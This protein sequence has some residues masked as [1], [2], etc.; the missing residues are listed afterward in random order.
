MAVWSDLRRLMV[1]AA[2]NMEAR[3]IRLV[4]HPGLTVLMPAGSLRALHVGWWG[5]ASLLLSSVFLAPL[6]S[7]LLPGQWNTKYQA[8]SPRP[9]LFSI[10]H[11]EGHWQ[12]F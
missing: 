3:G 12:A 9:F 7:F 8:F 4:I 5:G 11:I 1:S 10:P 2:N 6:L